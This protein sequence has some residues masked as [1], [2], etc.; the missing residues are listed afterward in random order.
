MVAHLSF[1]QA[2]HESVADAAL[3]LTEAH[4]ILRELNND[5]LLRAA[6][7]GRFASVLA[8][9]GT[10]ATAAR[11]LSSS[12][13]LMQEIGA[14]PTWFGG[15]SAKTLTVIHTRLDDAPFAEA[16]EHGRSLTAEEGCGARPRFARGCRYLRRARAALT[17]CIARVCL[18]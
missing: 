3:L 7:V 17:P 2:V 15:I 18:I 8:V 9:A 16:W 14:R 5:R 11:V 13:A 12:E 4:G 10:A 1:P 6:A